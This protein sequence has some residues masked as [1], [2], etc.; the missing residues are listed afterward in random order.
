TCPSPRSSAYMVMRWVVPSASSSGA[1]GAAPAELP[2]AV[3]AAGVSTAEAAP[4]SI[5]RRCSPGLPAFVLV[6]FSV[7]VLHPMTV[8]NSLA[9]PLGPRVLWSTQIRESLA[10]AAARRRLRG[11]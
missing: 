11:R 8:Q 6:L 9:H 7:M 3:R 5:V 1:L 4:A 2:I 10:V